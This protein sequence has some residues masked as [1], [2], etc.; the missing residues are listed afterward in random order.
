M[1]V[2]GRASRATRLR[3]QQTPSQA[4]GPD[5]LYCSARG[6]VAV[7]GIGGLTSHSS[8]CRF[9]ARLNSGVRALAET[10]HDR[11]VVAATLPCSRKP[12]APGRR[13]TASFPRTP[14]ASRW[15]AAFHG[16]AH[17]RVVSGQALRGNRLAYSSCNGLWPFCRRRPNYSFKPN[18]SRCAGQVGLTQAL[19]LV[20]RTVGGKDQAGSSI[21]LVRGVCTSHAR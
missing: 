17:C 18:L 10:S 21:S 8:R 9:A 5:L 13:A 20:S 1:R 2:L 3:S 6:W 19:G 4:V 7:L 16:A 15:L 14:G 12:V 11:Y